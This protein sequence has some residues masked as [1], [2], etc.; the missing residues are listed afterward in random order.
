MGGGGSATVGRSLYDVLGVRRDASAE[1]IR[2]AYRRAALREHPDRNPADKE[3]AEER[4]KELGRAYEVL[5]DP[6]RRHAY[7]SSGRVA[8]A[9]QAFSYNDEMDGIVQSFMHNVLIN[10]ARGPVALRNQ[11]K[12]PG[13]LWAAVGMSLLGGLG[14][15]A[16]AAVQGGNIRLMFAYAALGSLL[17]AGAHVLVDAVAASMQQLDSRQQELLLDMLGELIRAVTEDVGAA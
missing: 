9:A 6:E 17:G 14:G 10:L 4:F 2:R 7:D 1:D 8:G 12:A 5:R 15:L 3:R 13:A 16:L 11:D